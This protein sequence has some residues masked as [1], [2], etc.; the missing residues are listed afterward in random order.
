MNV[1]L[2]W[3]ARSCEG[4]KYEILCVTQVS[5]VVVHVSLIVGAQRQCL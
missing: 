5:S 4:E 3:I 2:L 1:C